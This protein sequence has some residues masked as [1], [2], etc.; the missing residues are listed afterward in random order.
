MLLGIYRGVMEDCLTESINHSKERVQHNSLL[1]K[2]QANFNNIS[3]Q[4]KV[5]IE[6]S[7]WLVYKTALLR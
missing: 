3:K 6:S 5:A 1:A 2:K 7:K 4:I